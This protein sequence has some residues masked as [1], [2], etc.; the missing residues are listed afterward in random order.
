MLFILQKEFLKIYIVEIWGSSSWSI[1]N[2]QIYS[3]LINFIGVFWF[4]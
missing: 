4:I 3:R 1:D 2:I